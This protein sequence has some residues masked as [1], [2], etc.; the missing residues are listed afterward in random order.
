MFRT[1]L[2]RLSP[3]AF[4]LA[5][6]CDESGPAP[7][8]LRTEQ[9]LVVADDAKLPEADL[10]AEE[11]GDAERLPLDD[12]NMT[13]ECEDAQILNDEMYD[14]VDPAWLEA[15]AIAWSE[16]HIEFKPGVT[17]TIDPDGGGVHA[18]PQNPGGPGSDL[19][20]LCAGACGSSACIK[21]VTST[22]ITCKNPPEGCS[23]CG[24]TC[25]LGSKPK[26]GKGLF[27]Y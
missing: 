13:P 2:T 9:I 20:C 1:L 23:D 5:V 6:A 18:A 15:N 3:I 11:L 19:W 26:P 24:G 21:E 14:P 8:D 10:A 27:I 7:D 4:V 25:S 17:L 16:S 12:E 22:S